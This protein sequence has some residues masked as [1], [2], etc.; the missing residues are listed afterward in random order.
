M[1]DDRYVRVWT[2]LDED[3]LLV[4]DAHGN[5]LKIE[6]LSAGTRE[7]VFLAIRLA[8][9][10]MYA[11]R[12]AQ[13]PLVLDDVLVNCDAVRAKAPPRCCANSPPTAISC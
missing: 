13:L 8:L 1:T 5:S 6:V 10:S 9:V 2:P 11:R 4:D 7:Q 3:T 12:G